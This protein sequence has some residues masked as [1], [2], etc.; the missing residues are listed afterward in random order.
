MIHRQPRPKRR[1]GRVEDMPQSEMFGEIMTQIGMGGTDFT[2]ASR[3]ANAAVREGMKSRA[4]LAFASLGA[5]GKNSSNIERD[6][7]VDRVDAQWS[8]GWACWC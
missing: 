3:L 1:R 2:C 7:H 8:I 6:A 4:V 5:G